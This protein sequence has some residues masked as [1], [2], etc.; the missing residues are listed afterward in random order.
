MADEDLGAEDDCF[1]FGGTVIIPTKE[2]T[3]L[4][5]SE[6][7]L[8]VGLTREVQLVINESN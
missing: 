8:R 2:V 1:A 6:L 4:L 7:T 3:L 5:Q